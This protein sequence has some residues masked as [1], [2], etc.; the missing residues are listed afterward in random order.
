VSLVAYLLA[1]SVLVCV[2]GR[3]LLLRCTATGEHPRLAIRAW[4]AVTLSVPAAWL[5]S[6]AT[7]TLL[8]AHQTRPVRWLVSACRSV[9][10][11]AV[12]VDRP[13]AAAVAG[14]TRTPPTWSSYARNYSSS[15]TPAALRWCGVFAGSD[16]FWRGVDDAGARPT[17][18]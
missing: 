15:S 14:Q 9:L 11:T 13:L 17:S 2:V 12:A 10:H 1:Y 6:G 18:G 16:W 7:L 8:L 5:A 4:Q 3:R